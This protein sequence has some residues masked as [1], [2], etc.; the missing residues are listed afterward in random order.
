[1]GLAITVLRHR[2]SEDIELHYNQAKMIDAV[3]GVKAAPVLQL[4]TT[5]PGSPDGL[6]VMGLDFN[7]EASF[8]L[9]DVAEGEKPQINP[10]AFLAGDIILISQSFAAKHKI[11]LGG[12]FTTDGTPRPG[13]PLLVFYVSDLEATL[14]KVKAAGG[15]IVKPIFAFPGGR[16]FQFTDP[17]GYEVSAWSQT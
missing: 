10:L 2:N 13:G 7:R 14:A 11:K 4:G 8:R 1:M 17:D 3:S 16:R 5:M 15:T 6:L 9:W 12:G